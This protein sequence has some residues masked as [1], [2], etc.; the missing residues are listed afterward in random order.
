MDREKELE[1][2]ILKLKKEKKNLQRKLIYLKNKHLNNEKC[3]KYRDNN[4]DKVN[5]NRRDN[6]QKNKD[7]IRLTQNKWA[8]NNREKISESNKKATK[9]YRKT[10]AGIKVSFKHK[11]KSRGLNMDNFEEIYKRY[12]ETTNCDYCNVLL[13]N[14]KTM[15]HSHITGEFRNIL[16]CG[17]NVR[18]GEN[19]L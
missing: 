12:V 2:L 10:E 7:S 14:N 5:K 11:W 16:C 19:N 8:E 3:K 15:D 17:C 9:K 13:T 4:K 1:E 6:Y 18:R